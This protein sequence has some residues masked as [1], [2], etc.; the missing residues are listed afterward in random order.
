META[1]DFIFISLLFLST[2]SEGNS[3][4]FV[5]DENIALLDKFQQGDR[6]TEIV[7]NRFS[8]SYPIR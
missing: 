5:N 4:A 7:Y 6:E 3:A 1:L 8:Q 2:F